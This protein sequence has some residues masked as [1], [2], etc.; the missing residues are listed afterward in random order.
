MDPYSR[1]LSGKESWSVTGVLLRPLA[2]AVEINVASVTS[3]L[4]RSSM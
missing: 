1:E 3:Q 4:A 2:G